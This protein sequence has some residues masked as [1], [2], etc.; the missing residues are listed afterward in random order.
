MRIAIASDHGGLPLKEELVPFIRALGLPAD[1][2]AMILGGSARA[3]LGSATPSWP[4]C[5]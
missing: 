5:P 1:L 3:L 4:S 2:T